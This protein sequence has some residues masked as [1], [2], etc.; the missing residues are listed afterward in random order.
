MIDNHHFSLCTPVQC[1]ICYYT[2][3]EASN[4]MAD[5]N[6]GTKITLY[7]CVTVSSE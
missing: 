1:Y 4:I 3:N 6:Q 7:W 5:N 2:V